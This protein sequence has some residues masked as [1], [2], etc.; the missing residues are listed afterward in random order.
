M[1]EWEGGVDAYSFLAQRGRTVR[2]G[3]PAASAANLQALTLRAECKDSEMAEK[4][5]GSPILGSTCLLS[6]HGLLFEATFFPGP[7]LQTGKLFDSE[8]Y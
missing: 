1:F 6:T 5:A 8:R 4:Q 2:P 7:G 3:L